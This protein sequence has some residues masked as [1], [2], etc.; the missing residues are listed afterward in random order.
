MG[1]LRY[2][3]NLMKSIYIIYKYEMYMYKH[4]I[5]DYVNTSHI[6]S[7]IIIV[8]LYKREYMTY[9]DEG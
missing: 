6:V 7:I 3:H 8:L 2:I 1:T 5:L 9:I 4:T